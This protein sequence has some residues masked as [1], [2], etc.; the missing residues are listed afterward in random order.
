LLPGSGAYVNNSGT[1]SAAVLDFGI[2]AGATGPAGADGADGQ[3]AT[4]SVGTVTT[5]A[6]GSTPFVNNGGTSQDAIL[7]FGLPG[8][9]VYHKGDFLTFNNLSTAG[10]ITGSAKQV[11]FTIPLLYPLASDITG[12][13]VVY[14]GTGGGAFILRQNGQY[15]NGSGNGINPVNDHVQVKRQDGC[16]CIW[17]DF[18]SAANATNNDV[19]GVNFNG[20]LIFT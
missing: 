4:I 9:N 11:R 16:M 17:A 14:S 1:A 2:P 18:S 15:T 7:N 19:I 5:L 13:D 8:T 10:F 6:P 20:G 3:A 12:A